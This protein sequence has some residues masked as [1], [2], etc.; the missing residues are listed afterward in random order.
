MSHILLI[1]GSL[2]AG[3][4]NTAAIR[5]AQEVAPDGVTTTIYEGIGSL[6]HFNPD[7]D[8]EGER[9]HPA[10]AD[11]R[12]QV[13]TADGVV[14]CTPEYAGALPGSLKNLLE[15]TVGDGGTYRKPIAWINVSGPA[16]PTGGADAHDS[17]RKVL[18]YVHANIIESACLRLPLTRDAVA[19]DG[20][21]HDPSTREQ[22]SAMLAR[23]VAEAST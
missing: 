2:R 6:P 15:W 14:V 7:D 5:T 8:R 12:A 9:V 4:T 23:L 16:A 19:D 10:V 17:L 21:L 22:I 20:T 11:L 3:S 18:G 13:S 1:S